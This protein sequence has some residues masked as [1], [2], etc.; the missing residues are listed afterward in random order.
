LKSISI[1]G[2]LKSFLV[3]VEPGKFYSI[4][5]ELCI[6]ISIDRSSNAVYIRMVPMRTVQ[7][8]GSS[9]R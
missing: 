1:K 2:A 5:S 9:L 4:K 6:K 3:R 8:R 7:A